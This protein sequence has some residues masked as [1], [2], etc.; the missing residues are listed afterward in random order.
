MSENLKP[1]P[2]CGG[3]AVFE[4]NTDSNSVK[5]VCKSCGASTLWTIVEVQN[6]IVEKW[7]TRSRKRAV[8]IKLC[9]CCGSNGKLWQ[10]MDGTFIIQ[11]INCS[12]SSNY[13]QTAEE[14]ITAWNAR[15]KEIKP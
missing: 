15:Y 1:C 8:Q 11:C 5:I 13:Y 12:I 9:P 6:Y 4:K 7:N 2:F 14:A 10:A 3:E